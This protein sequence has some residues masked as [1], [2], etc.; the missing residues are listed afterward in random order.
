MG[1]KRALAF[2]NW[3][4]PEAPVDNIIG[5][6]ALSPDGR[7]VMTQ[8][9]QVFTRLEPRL[10][11]WDFETG[12]IIRRLEQ[13]DSL[14]LDIVFTPD[15]KQALTGHADGTLTLWDLVSGKP[16]R[17]M[18]S[19]LNP[20][21]TIDISSDGRY[22]ISPGFAEDI[23][24][25]DL[26]TGELLRTFVQGHLVALPVDDVLFLPGDRQ[27]ATSGGDGTIVI[28][29]LAS[30]EQVRRLTGLEGDAGSHIIAEAQEAPFV[31]QLAL[32]PDGRHLLSTG[33]DGT[34]LLWDLAT[35]KS[36]RRFVGHSQPAASVDISPDGRR[37][38]SGAWDE[39]EMILWDLATAKPV[40]SFP[41]RRLSSEASYVPFIAFHPDGQTVLTDD[42]DGSL[43]KW[44]LA[45]PSPQDLVDWIEG[46]GRC[47]N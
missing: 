17:R 36:L 22:A 9:W 18:G 10:T 12:T 25:W 44:Q 38:L 24:Y 41:F 26:E 37:A 43:V 35:G 31:N 5:A 33:E 20:A 42:V 32:A 27:I 19:H 47:A 29:D 14:V 40:R 34:L 23:Q 46:I 3:R 1:S 15:N 45:E 13:P 21:T 2:G 4:D 6:F 7:Q 11:L 30:G 16:I 28:W 8:S 39:S